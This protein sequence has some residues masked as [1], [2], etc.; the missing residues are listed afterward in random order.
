MVV[1]DASHP[2]SRPQREIAVVA[3]FV[4]EAV[5]HFGIELALALKIAVE[6]AAGEAGACHHVIDG[7]GNESA[8]IEQFAR[9]LDDPFPDLL[10][11]LRR[12]RHP[13]LPG[14]CG[15][16]TTN[17]MFENMRPYV[18]EHSFYR[19]CCDCGPPING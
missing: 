15:I 5:D 14:R 9:T 12:I 18:L 17:N 4:D 13:S 1:Q 6:A 19:C 3:N 11:M 16:I 7:D 10:A 2:V 8:V